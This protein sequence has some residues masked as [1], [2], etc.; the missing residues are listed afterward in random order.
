MSVV[1]LSL[2]PRIIPRRHANGSVLEL[3]EYAGRRCRA[4]SA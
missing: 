3:S 4:V 1:P 2:A